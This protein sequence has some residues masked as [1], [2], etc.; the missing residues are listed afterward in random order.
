[1]AL[2][3]LEALPAERNRYTNKWTH[4]GRPAK[5]AFDSQAQI[6]L[7]KDFCNRKKC[8]NC[9]IGSRIFSK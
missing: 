3:W 9:G 4:A 6:T 8:L 5:S 1:M 2:N 7:F